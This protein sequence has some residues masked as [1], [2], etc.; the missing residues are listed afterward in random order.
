MLAA[1]PQVFRAG[2]MREK[3]FMQLINPPSLPPSLLTCLLFI[4]F[5]DQL[6]LII[7]F[8]AYLEKFVIALTKRENIFFISSLFSSSLSSLFLIKYF[9]LF[10]FNCLAIYLFI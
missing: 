9:S 5:Y 2:F 7:S 10:F 6:K 4:S 8:L 3:S 1:G